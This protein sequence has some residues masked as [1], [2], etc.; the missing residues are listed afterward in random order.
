MPNILYVQSRH[1]HLIIKMY[2]I[3][4]VIKLTNCSIGVHRSIHDAD[5]VYCINTILL[6]THNIRGRFI[7]AI[8]TAEFHPQKQN[9]PEYFS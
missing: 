4:V 5:T 6:C 7:F 8:F 1:R 9:C 2:L 3:L